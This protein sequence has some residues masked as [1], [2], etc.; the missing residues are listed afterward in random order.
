MTQD[1]PPS[2]CPECGLEVRLGDERCR[3]CD[4]ALDQPLSDE[5]IAAH[6]AGHALV[7][8]CV[9]ATVDRIEAYFSEFGAVTAVADS[10]DG[11]ADRTIAAGGSAAEW[12]T[13]PGDP[14]RWRYASDSDLNGGDV[15]GEDLGTAKALIRQH[16]EAHAAL[17]AVVLEA[18]LERSVVS[19]S[20][21]HALLEGHQVTRP[22]R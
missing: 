1:P 13:C 14:F 2:T 15:T 3:R 22:S 18:R 12:E 20:D 6:E 8:Y 4:L 16:R 11:P 17:T 7:A 10:P 5:R 9:G 21:V 19:G